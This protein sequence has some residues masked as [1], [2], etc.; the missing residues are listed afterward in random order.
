M[1]PAS[2]ILSVYVPEA[3][4][5]AVVSKKSS[6]V[7]TNWFP[8]YILAPVWLHFTVSVP[9]DDNVGVDEVTVVRVVPV[10]TGV[11]DEV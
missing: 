9:G 2:V 6:V 10:L 7:P 5:L 8:T 1:K 4:P 3:M 11:V